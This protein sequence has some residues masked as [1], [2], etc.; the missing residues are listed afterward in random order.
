MDGWM[1]IG[2]R[3]TGRI[4]IGKLNEMLGRYELV[5]VTG[6]IFGFKIFDILNLIT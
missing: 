5:S 1:G 4:P 3:K 6:V 2:P